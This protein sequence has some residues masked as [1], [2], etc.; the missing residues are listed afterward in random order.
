MF[1]CIS[2]H[3][4]NKPLILSRASLYSSFNAV[5]LLW[6]PDCSLSLLSML[7][8]LL[9]TFLFFCWLFLLNFMAYGYS[10]LLLLILQSQ[11]TFLWHSLCWSFGLALVPTTDVF[12]DAFSTTCLPAF[13]SAAMKSQSF[14]V[15]FYTNTFSWRLIFLPIPLIIWENIILN[16]LIFILEF[17][18]WYKIIF[19]TN[20]PCFN[21]YA[22]KIYYMP[23]YKILTQKGKENVNLQLVRQIRNVSK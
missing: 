16:Y 9:I 13:Y 14:A 12:F 10:W 23:A 22:L 8:L 6:C 15:E 17:V 5:P 11:G 1:F 2:C 20:P 21:K 19:I 4:S 7:L 18:P 3:L